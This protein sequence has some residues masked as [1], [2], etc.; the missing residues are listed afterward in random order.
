MSPNVTTRLFGGTCFCTSP[1][2][3]VF[4]SGLDVRKHFPPLQM[5][6]FHRNA[7]Q[8]HTISHPSNDNDATL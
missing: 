1:C 2:S 4:D 6:A 8:I 7:L 3:G 5:I